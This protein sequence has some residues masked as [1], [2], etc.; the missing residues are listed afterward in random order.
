MLRTEFYF[1][2]VLPFCVLILTSMAE[3]PRIQSS[4]TKIS[5]HRLEGMKSAI[6]DL[7][8]GV[9]KQKEYPP[10]PYSPYHPEFIRLL[11]V[12]CGVEWESVKSTSDPKDL[13][14]K[15]DGYNDIM[16][17]EIE[18]RFGRDIFRILTARAKE[19]AKSK[20]NKPNR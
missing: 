13:S 1:L 19:R 2:G 12:E 20:T 11:K 16:R 18:H 4:P 9:L 15:T 14:E 6:A 3:E 5:S 7:K 17:A 8:K 10:L